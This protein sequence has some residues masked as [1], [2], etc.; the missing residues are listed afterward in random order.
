MTQKEE[1]IRCYR[2]RAGELRT[3]AEHFM[4]GNRDMLMKMAD[5]YDHFAQQL[6][7]EAWDLRAVKL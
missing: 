1:N 5:H 7:H 2:A 4:P 6:E 3:K